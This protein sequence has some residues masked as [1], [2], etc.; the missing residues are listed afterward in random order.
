MN[1]APIL[2]NLWP[3]DLNPTDVPFRERTKT[4]LQ[5]HGL[6]DDP[7][8]FNSLTVT[9]LRHR[10]NPDQDHEAWHDY[11]TARYVTPTGL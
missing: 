7:T 2:T 5:R 10:L 6:F 4:I 1:P 3:H 9:E 8:K 11:M